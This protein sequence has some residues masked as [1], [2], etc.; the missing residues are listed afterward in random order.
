MKEVR[1]KRG[2][3][4]K[5]DGTVKT[6]QINFRTTVTGR[7]MIEEMCGWYDK[8][9]SEIITKLIYSQYIEEKLRR[10]EASIVYQSEDTDGDWGDYYENHEEYGNENDDF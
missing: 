2:R 10:D 3:P 4:A 1:K 8:N 7:E 9:M 5:D 6:C